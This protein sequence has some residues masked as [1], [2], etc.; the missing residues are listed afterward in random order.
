M[1]TSST[2]TERVPS[3]PATSHTAPAAISAGTLSAAGEP[4][5]R[6]PPSE[7]RPWIWVEPISSSASTTPGHAA[8]TASFLPSVAPGNGRADANL[9]AVRRHVHERRNA[10]EIN[11]Q[12]GPHE[13]RAQLNQE[14]GAAGERFGLAVGAS[15]KPDGIL[16]RLR[17]LEL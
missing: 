5:Q 15:E 1:I 7:A 4:L 6:L 10:L 8:F 9:V 14:V 16:H 17:R 2:G 13:V 12:A 11:D 3:G